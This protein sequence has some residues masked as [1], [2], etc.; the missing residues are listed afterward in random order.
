MTHWRET[1]SRRLIP[2]LRDFLKERLPEYMI[3]VAWMVLEKLPLTSNGKIDRGALPAPEGRYEGMGDYI[4]PRTELERILAKV[5]G[6]VLRLDRVGVQDNFFELGG[7]SLLVVQMM[8]RLRQFGL[9]AEIRRI[10]DS[11]SLAELAGTLKSDSCQTPIPSNLIPIG[12]E[13]ISP[14]MLPL[15]GLRQKHIDAIVKV[16]PGARPTFRISILWRPCRRVCSSTIFSASA[17]VM[18]MWSVR[19]CPSRLKIDCRNS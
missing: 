17:V 19:Y 14:E 8:E 2:G 3:P 15:V 4:P 13:S 11:G 9:V 18:R 7:H 6:D 12:C 10:Y 16:I 5:W 1:S